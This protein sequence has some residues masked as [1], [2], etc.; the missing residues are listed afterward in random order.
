MTGEAHNDNVYLSKAQ[1]HSD[2]TSITLFSH[3]YFSIVNKSAVPIEFNW[4]AFVSDGEE[5]EKKQRLLAQMQ[6]EEE[7]E[8]QEILRADD[9]DDDEDGSLDSDDS[10]DENEL[11]EKRERRKEKALQTLSRRYQSIKQAVDEDKMLFQDEIF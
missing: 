10:Y 1:L 5:S 4:K 9:N 2:P 3:Q 6:K 7:E 11:A 8:R